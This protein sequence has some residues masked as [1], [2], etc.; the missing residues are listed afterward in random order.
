MLSGEVAYTNSIVLDVIQSG[1]DLTI[2]HTQDEN[3]SHYATDVVET[4][5]F[6]TRD[7]PAIS[8]TNH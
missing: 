4:K 5:M 1:T 8:N 7:K 2:Y 3:A 6:H